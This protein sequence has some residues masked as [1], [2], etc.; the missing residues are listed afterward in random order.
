M[1]HASAIWQGDASETAIRSLTICDSPPKVLNVAGPETVSIRWLAEQFGEL[2][3]VEPAFAN[4]E[5]D[6]S[7]VIN[8]SKSHQLFGYPKVTLGQM[9]E[10]VAQWVEAGGTSLGKPTR[11]QEREGEF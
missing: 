3:R 1:G 9:V 6:T 10:W 5:L 4:E 11:F 2:L 8:A 7:Y